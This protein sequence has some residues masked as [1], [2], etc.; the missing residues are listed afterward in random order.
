MIICGVG[1]QGNLLVERIIGMSAMRQ[2]YSVRSADTFG[3]AQRGG[4]V[5]SHVR[6]GLELYSSLVPQGR[7]DVLI[8]LEPGEA[9]T[10]SLKFLGN[11]SLA[12]VNTCPFPPV[13]VKI[14]ERTYP[15][16]EKVLELLRKV[17]PHVIDL[18]A[19]TLARE[20]AGT[21]RSMNVVMTGVL[22]GVGVLPLKPETVKETVKELT[23]RFAEGNIRAF[24]AGFEI[25]KASPVRAG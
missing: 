20:T 6:V 24:D 14:G 19:T 9:L 2:G 3:A 10:T 4:S 16:V 12:L 22:M 11:Q 13:K 25:G 5:L 23:G 1:G 21:E 7:C 18:D 17:T 15:P 8:G